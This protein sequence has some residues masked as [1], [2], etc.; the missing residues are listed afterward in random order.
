MSTSMNKDAK[1]MST[2][3]HKYSKFQIKREFKESDFFH[4]DLLKQVEDRL[5]TEPKCSHLW[6]VWRW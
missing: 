6:T 4:D 1:K 2:I 3:V 5:E